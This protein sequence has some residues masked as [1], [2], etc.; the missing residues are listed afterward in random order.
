MKEIFDTTKHNFIR[1]KKIRV[2]RVKDNTTFNVT[3]YN[4][5]SKLTNVPVQKI[6]YILNCDDK[7]ANGY[8]FYDW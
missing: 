5:A 3:G 2:V 7:T 4:Q 8:K 6:Q 1:R